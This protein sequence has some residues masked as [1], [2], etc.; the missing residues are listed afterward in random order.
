[1][2]I[3][4]TGSD[5]V[6][7]ACQRSVFVGTVRQP[8][9]QTTPGPI[10]PPS[11]APSSTPGS[12]PT[13]TPSPTAAPTPTASPSPS[14]TSVAN[15]PGPEAVYFPSTGDSGPVSVQFTDPSNPSAAPVVSNNNL[16]FLSPPVITGM[17]THTP[18]EGEFI[19]LAGSGFAAGGLNPIA[20]VTY[21][22]G[23]AAAQVGCDADAALIGDDAHMTLSAPT[24]YCSGDAA[25]DAGN[26]A[27]YALPDLQ[28]Q[29]ER[30]RGA[31][32]PADPGE[33]GRLVHPAAA[34][35]PQEPPCT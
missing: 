32:S 4:I 6:D 31:D 24:T 25:G 20:G 23:A 13:P 28:L 15:P 19:A 27:G 9:D 22:Q 21:Y 12:S 16:T 14:P 30:H 18:A 2:W 35:R 17:S 3:E 29:H 10:T 8:N 5:L 26:A 33:R 34:A 1:M 7:P 11:P